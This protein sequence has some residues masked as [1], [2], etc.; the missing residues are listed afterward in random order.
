MA[1]LVVPRW[2]HAESQVDVKVLLVYL[3]LCNMRVLSILLA[4]SF[5][6][7]VENKEV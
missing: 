3:Y 1:F 2:L 7:T 5:T 6:V 4:I